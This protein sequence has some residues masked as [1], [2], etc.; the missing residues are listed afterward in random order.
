MNETDQYLKEARQLYA[1]TRGAYFVLTASN[2]GTHWVLKIPAV[3]ETFTGTIHRVLFE[4]IYY[5]K[6]NRELAVRNLKTKPYK[7]I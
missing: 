1:V 5:V 3:Q 6:N 4:Y 2:D 7:L